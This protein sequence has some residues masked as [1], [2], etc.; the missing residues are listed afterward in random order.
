MQR[1]HS[2]HS[3]SSTVD[4]KSLNNESK[5]RHRH[6]QSVKPVLVIHSGAGVMRTD[7]PV[8]EQEKYRIALRGAL[9]AGH[10]V[11]SAGGESIDAVTAAVSFMEDCPLFNCG[12]GAVFTREGT[13][14]LETSLMLSKPPSAAVGP[15][16]IPPTRRGI[17]VTLVRRA[18]NP[19]QLARALY[20]NP[21]ATPHSMMSGPAAEELGAAFGGP[22]LVDPSYFWTEKRWREHRRG[23]GLPE[24]PLPEHGKHGEGEGGD[25]MVMPKGTVGAVALDS[26]GCIAAATSTGGLTNKIPGRVG[27]T[28]VMGAGFWAEE[29]EVSGWVRRKLRKLFKGTAKSGVGISCTGDGDYFIRRSAAVE[30]AHRMQFLAQPLAK[31]SKTVIEE[32]RVD[33]GMGG[34]IAVDL[35]GNYFFP[36]NSPGMY[37][38][39]I[40]EEGIPKVA[41]F[42]FE[43][44]E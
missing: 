8:E 22:K 42:D 35:A 5:P 30:V 29:F 34:L 3:L 28:P 17:S 15:A 10:A 18:K 24:E 13:N 6:A 39:V 36:M 41:I 21:Q 26:R 43:E 38:G 19:I 27:D 11:L 1:R 32:L 2:F 14:E 33:G 4:E 23:L 37:R 20:L 7:T 31:A 16:P 40:T 44:L 25:M 12:H 9:K